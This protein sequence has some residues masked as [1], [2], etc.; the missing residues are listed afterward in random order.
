M[1]DLEPGGRGYSPS[2]EVNF[3][4]EAQY[5]VKP[6]TAKS[7]DGSDGGGDQHGHHVQLIELPS[8]EPGKDGMQNLSPL[9]VSCPVSD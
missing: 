3:R 1:S 7:G 8:K 4:A 2:F 6:A 5:V 9:A